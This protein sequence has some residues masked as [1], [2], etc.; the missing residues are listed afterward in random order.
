M[1]SLRKRDKK[2]K[3]IVILHFMTTFHNVTAK[4]ETSSKLQRC[5]S[6]IG[7]LESQ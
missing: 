2:S 1:N 6:P 7:K 5:L 4:I 3:N